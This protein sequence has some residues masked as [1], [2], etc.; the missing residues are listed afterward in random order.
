MCKYDPTYGQGIRLPDETDTKCKL[1]LEHGGD[2]GHG[3]N[4]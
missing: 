3:R 4:G 1:T 2:G